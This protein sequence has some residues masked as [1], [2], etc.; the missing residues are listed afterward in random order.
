[1]K[2]YNKI[3]AEV[4]GKQIDYTLVYVMDKNHCI[5]S[6]FVYTSE[7]DSTIEDYEELVLSSI[8]DGDNTRDELD[9]YQDVSDEIV[10]YYKFEITRTVERY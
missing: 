3:K 9:I 4:M 5:A 7:V 6:E 2:S 1:M 10:G 8:V